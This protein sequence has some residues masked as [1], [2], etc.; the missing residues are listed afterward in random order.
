MSWDGARPYT[1]E[2]WAERFAR[3]LLDP[4]PLARLLPK[5]VRRT[6][7]ERL[8]SLPWRPWK[9]WKYVEPK[10]PVFRG[11]RVKI[12]RHEDDMID[13]IKVAVPKA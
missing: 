10:Y 6:W 8:L 5:P 12:S 13:S 1:S 7:Y 2:M 9:K 4:S 11:G 3:M